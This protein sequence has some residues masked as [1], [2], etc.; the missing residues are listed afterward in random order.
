MNR[1]NSVSGQSVA[2]DRVLFAV[3]V[4]AMALP[5]YGLAQKFPS[6]AVTIVVGQKE[7]GSTDMV[8]RTFQQ[9]FSKYLNTPVVVSNVEG[10]GGKIGRT[11]V[12]KA[13]PNG[14][15]LIVTGFP[16]SLLNQKL[17]NPDY[18]F[19]RMTP[20]YNIQGGDYNA[21]A[22]PFDSPIKTIDELKKQGQGK[23]VKISGSGIGNNAYLSYY[24]LKVRVG[25]NSTY[26]PYD[27]GSDAAL[28]VISK[29][30]DAGTGSLISFQPLSEQKRLRVIAVTGP[31]RSPAF[32]NTPNLIE[33][34]YPGAGFDITLGLFGPPDISADVAKTLEDAAVK[35]GAD[36]AFK[37]VAKKADFNLAPA[38]AAELKKMLDEQSRMLD[39][40]VPLI[41]E[42]MRAGKKK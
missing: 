41:K 8:A 11:Q 29:Q 2:A 28:A 23:N 31:K 17:D 33:L 25:I 4:I 27:S 36:P 24:F 22:V 35:A 39:D 19:E 32:P 37:E 26:I 40:V 30:V 38:T 10:A 6:G 42:S 13:K 3:S 20:I 21:V 34:G 9:Y 14:Y 7:G 16:A 15:T 18:K 1:E 12:Y 5:G